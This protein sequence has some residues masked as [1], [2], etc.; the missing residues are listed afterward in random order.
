VIESI[1]KL[2][3]QTRQYDIL[4]VEDDPAVRGQL[5]SL[6]GSLFHRVWQAGDGEEGLQLFK[7]HP[8]DL[9]MTDIA[10]PR[11]DGLQMARR[12]RALDSSVP[13]ILTTG[14][15]EEK[16]FLESIEIGVDAYLPKPIDMPLLIRT[17]ERIV[18]AAG[19]R[20]RMAEE[21]R[22]FSILTE[23]SIVSKSNLSGTITYVNDNL[24]RISGYTREELIG[25]NHNL[26]RHPDNS[27]AMYDDMWQ[28]ILSGKVWKGRV[29]N[30]NKNGGTFLADTIIIPFL[31]PEGRIIEFIAIRQ[32]VTDYVM[33]MR[34]MQQEK[35][36]KEEDARINAAKESFLILFT[37]EL[38]TPLNAIINF[39][40]YIRDKLEA[41]Q[42]IDP[43]KELGLVRSIL[44]NGTEMLAH[45]N[46]ILDISKLKS[47][48]LAYNKQLVPLEETVAGLLGQ[49]ES[50]M[51]QKAIRCQTHIDTALNVYSDEYRL[52]QVLSNLLSNAFKYGNG[53]LLIEASERA[54]AVELS[55]E[56]NGPGIP[57]KQSVF[58]L[59]EQGEESLLS[60]RGQGTGIGL[61]LVKLFCDDLGIGYRLE[62]SPRLGG[63]RFVLRF[64][65]GRA[66][67]KEEKPA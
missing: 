8:V 3:E 41:S 48:K 52:R 65:T 66:A 59:Y 43:A 28:T 46:N 35:Q 30:L 51:T 56:D 6:L 22:Y 23:A 12:I 15:S 9:V 49:F 17:L 47:H 31:D 39:A 54:D 64:E 34:K 38:K 19:A 14:F 10:M 24:C 16:F 62:D 40:K 2:Q 27:D 1:K 36:K 60:R 29:E 11:M 20:R 61:Y 42:T 37:H 44:N 55:V 63:T 18:A 58:G 67:R 45:V 50:I 25:R 57:D 4:F 7:E 5:A 32:D 21:S 33:L 53:E 13:V 26:F